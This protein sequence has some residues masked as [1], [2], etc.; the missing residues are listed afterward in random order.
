MAK[1]KWVA[2]D[3]STF[4]SEQEAKTYEEQ[5]RIKA[6]LKE[7][8]SRKFDATIANIMAHPCLHISYIGEEEEEATD[9]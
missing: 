9:E 7:S 4:D 3:G 2:E 8:I 1:R 5:T 6:A